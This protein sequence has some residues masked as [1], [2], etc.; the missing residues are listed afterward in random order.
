MI[1]LIM[2]SNNKVSWERLFQN[3]ETRINLLVCE[4]YFMIKSLMVV[5][6]GRSEDTSTYFH[7]AKSFDVQIPRHSRIRSAV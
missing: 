7:E 2:I 5:K 4:F 6:F 1:F 3:N